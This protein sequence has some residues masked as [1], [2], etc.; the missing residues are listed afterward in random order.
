MKQHGFTLLEILVALAILAVALSSA[1]RASSAAIQTA[2]DLRL[3]VLAAWVAENRLAELRAL[4]AW[5]AAGVSEGNV[6]MVG[7]PL[8]WQQTVTST[9]NER[10][11]RL[12]IS[13]VRTGD[14]QEAALVRQVA[15][16]TQP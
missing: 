13:V 6:E 12:E 11:R 2:G 10:F 8:Q 1:I 15:Y 7:E 14:R 4:R 3:R 16:L 9:P 5:P